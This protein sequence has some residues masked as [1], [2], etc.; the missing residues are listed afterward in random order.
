MKNLSLNNESLQLN[1]GE[2]YLIIDALYLD[3]LKD[4]KV[5]LSFNDTISWIRESF[6]YNDTPFAIYKAKSDLFSNE[7]IRKVN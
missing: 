5:P 4:K 6:P 3:E 7:Q 2:S 1:N